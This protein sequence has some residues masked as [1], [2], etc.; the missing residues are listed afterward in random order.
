MLGWTGLLWTLF[1]PR[2]GNDIFFF[3]IPRQ[4]VQ[5]A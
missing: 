1:R 3:N 2:L 4:L 5:N